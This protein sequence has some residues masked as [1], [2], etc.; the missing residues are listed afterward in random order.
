MWNQADLDV[1]MTLH[2]NRHE[3][4]WMMKRT[5]EAFFN[6]YRTSIRNGEIFTQEAEARKLRSILAYSVS[7]RYWD[8]Q[9][10]QIRYFRGLALEDTAPIRVS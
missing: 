2:C 7:P 4:S 9:H 3:E 5:A 6:M 8:M 1:S 10:F